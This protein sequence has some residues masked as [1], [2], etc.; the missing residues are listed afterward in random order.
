MAERVDVAAIQAIS[1]LR[2]K[3]I[4]AG[5]DIHRTLGECLSQC[6]RVLAWVRGTQ[7]EFW[8]RQK[9]KREQQHATSKSDLQRAMIAKPDADPRAFIDQHRAIRRARRAVEE[10][11]DK[12]RAIQFWT[13]ELERQLT[14]FRGGVSHLTEAAELGLPRASQWLKDLTAHLDGYLAVAPPIPDIVAETEDKPV[15][16]DHKRMGS[17]GKA[18]DDPDPTDEAPQ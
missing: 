5:E 11:E 16:S 1:D 18:P 4:E 9:R 13:R 14:L 2:G 7:T 6:V 3:C 15:S 10:A 12:L 17:L 8:K